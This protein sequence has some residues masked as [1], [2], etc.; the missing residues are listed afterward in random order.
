MKKFSSLFAAV[1][2]AGWVN[3]GL[4]LI[5]DTGA[6][7]GKKGVGSIDAVTV[8]RP[9]INERE[10][11]PVFIDN[12][13]DAPHAH[14]VQQSCEGTALGASNSILCRLSAPGDDSDPVLSPG[15]SLPGGSNVGSGGATGSPSPDP[16]GHFCHDIDLTTNGGLGIDNE[17]VVVAPGDS[18]FLHSDPD[19]Q[20]P[21]DYNPACDPFSPL[22]TG[23]EQDCP[24]DG[25]GGTNTTQP[26]GGSNVGSSA[27]DAVD[28]P[29]TLVLFC[30]GLALL[31]YS[32]RNRQVSARIR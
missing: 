22:Y 27:P 1:V 16:I 15:D 25:N 9:G 21:P 31:G 12:T 30:L 2:C 4:A 17:V 28:A 8:P 23:S 26:P 24:P 3:S 13:R 11:G 10:H 14:G 29:A 20:L 19:P 6:P 18:D 32:Q 7:A 5:I